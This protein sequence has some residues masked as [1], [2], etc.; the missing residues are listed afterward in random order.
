MANDPL[1]EKSLAAAAVARG[2]SAAAISEAKRLGKD[3][4]R[5]K[6]GAYEQR[7]KSEKIRLADAHDRQQKAIAANKKWH[8]RR[9]VKKVEAKEQTRN[10]GLNINVNAKTGK[11]TTNDISST[12]RKLDADVR[13]SFFRADD[14]ETHHMGVKD[15]PP[16]RLKKELAYAKKHGRNDVTVK[17]P[18]HSEFSMSVES[19][20][21]LVA[22]NDGI[23]QKEF[24]QQEIRAKASAPSAKQIDQA[25]LEEEIRRDVWGSDVKTPRQD[26]NIAR[27]REEMN[28]AAGDPLRQA[29]AMADLRNATDERER[30]RASGIEKVVQQKLKAAIAEV[31][32]S[33]I[34]ALRKEQVRQRLGEGFRRPGAAENSD[35]S[36][37]Q[38]DEIAALRK[39]QVRQRLGAGFRRPGAAENSDSSD[40]IKVA[41]ARQKELSKVTTALKKAGGDP[42]KIKE[43]ERE[44]REV[45]SQK[46][47]L[48]R[49]TMRGGGTTG[50]GGE[51]PRVP[52]GSPQGG[53]WTD[54]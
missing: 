32:T 16:D 5:L 50:V 23:S 19:A 37:L 47:S 18:S 34:A 3:I 29:R 38:A 40:L 26:R 43:L 35:S 13:E 41:A 46:K 44:W 36:D 25:R 10:L 1:S 30:L 2:V 17:I 52:A 11:K 33:E 4:G 31:D 54:K 14:P 21:A 42:S 12:V 53:E 27:A 7:L 48:I 9:D 24:E 22:H 45:S 15:L 6:A 51:Q 28:K 20:A 8:N 49:A 39:E